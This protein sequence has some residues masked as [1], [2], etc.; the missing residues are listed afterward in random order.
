[1]ATR[2]VRSV[3]DRVEDAL[4]RLAQRHGIDMLRVA[5]GVVFLWFGLL[6]VVGASPVGEVVART[7][8]VLPMRPAVIALGVVETGIGLSLL[9]GRALRP[10]LAVFLVQ[11]C[12]TFLALVL[13]PDLTFQHGNPLLLS[14]LGEFVI[15]NL[16]LISA[17]IAIVGSLRRRDAE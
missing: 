16:V 17:G 14:T 1:M 4:D 2:P 11:M 8:L 3:L 6:K 13:A 9:T 10:A 7:L 15:K 5:L 12:G